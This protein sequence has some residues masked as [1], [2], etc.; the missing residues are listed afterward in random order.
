MGGLKSNLMMIGAAILVLVALLFA[1]RELNRAL[2][3]RD[4]GDPP[5]ALG[6][7]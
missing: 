3:G 2:A 5:A 7:D 1:K 4:G 6:S